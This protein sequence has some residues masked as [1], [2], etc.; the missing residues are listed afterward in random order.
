M[1]SRNVE[2]QHKEYFLIFLFYSGRC[3]GQTELAIQK[4][5]AHPCN[6]SESRVIEPS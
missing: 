3:T 5:V 4:G 6:M 2:P 1:A